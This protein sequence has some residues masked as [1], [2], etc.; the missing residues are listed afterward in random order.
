MVEFSPRFH[1]LMFS[2][3]KRRGAI[4][5]LGLSTLFQTRLSAR[6]IAQARVSNN[7]SKS[8]L[9]HGALQNKLFV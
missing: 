2:S 4:E 5:D 6:V 9:F 3:S 7:N 8:V 1:L